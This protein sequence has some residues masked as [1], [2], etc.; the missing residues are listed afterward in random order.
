[1]ITAVAA[2]ERALA[3]CGFAFGHGDGVSAAQ[4]SF[5]TAQKEPA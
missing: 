4:K 3:A 5:M 1:M 2:I